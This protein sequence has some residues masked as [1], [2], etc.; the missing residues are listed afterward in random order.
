MELAIA[1]PGAIAWSVIEPV[2][3]MR[4]STHR[5]GL[6]DFSQPLQVKNKDELGDLADDIN[7]MAHD[8]ERLQEATLAEQRAKV[9]SPPS[10]R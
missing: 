2:R 10:S 3:R 5:I 6:G 1:S 7:E 9:T 4:D 8:L